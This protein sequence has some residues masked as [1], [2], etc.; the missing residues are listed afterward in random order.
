MWEENIE[1]H[2]F[3]ILLNVLS[4][5]EISELG[6]H[7]SGPGLRHNR[8]GIRHALGIV[9]VAQVARDQKLMEKQPSS[10]LSLIVVGTTTLLMFGAAIGMFLF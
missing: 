2:G 5:E 6:E 1:R 4:S 10:K 8:A 3:A 7:L 9:P